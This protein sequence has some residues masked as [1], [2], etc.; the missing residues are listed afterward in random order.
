MLLASTL[1]RHL[2]RT[3]IMARH[4][5]QNPAPSR[6]QPYSMHSHLPPPVLVIVQ[7]PVYIMNVKWS[8]FGLARSWLT[9]STV[10]P[11]FSPYCIVSSICRFSSCLRC[12]SALSMEALGYQH[13]KSGQ[14]PHSTLGRPQHLSPG[15]SKIVKTH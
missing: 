8:H 13:T 15:G 9:P 14:H 1:D 2:Y 4:L 7:Q 3:I 6:S 5:S 11:H 10:I 12:Q